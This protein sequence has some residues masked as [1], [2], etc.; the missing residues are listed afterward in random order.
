MEKTTFARTLS[1]NLNEELAIQ[2]P[3]TD[4]ASNDIRSLEEWELVLA[5]GGDYIADW[6]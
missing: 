3:G 1:V 2:R 4:Q 6:G 5:A